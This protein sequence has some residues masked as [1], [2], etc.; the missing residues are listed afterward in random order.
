M[1]IAKTI[2]NQIKAID[3]CAL[4]AYGAKNYVALPENDNYQGGLDFK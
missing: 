3:F 1:E 2:M 4:G